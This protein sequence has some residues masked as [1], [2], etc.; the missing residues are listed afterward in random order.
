MCIFI[1]VLNSFVFVFFA[2]QFYIFSIWMFMLTHEA[3]LNWLLVFDQLDEKTLFNRT[4]CIVCNACSQFSFE[5]LFT[6]LFDENCKVAGAVMLFYSFIYSYNVQF[7]RTPSIYLSLLL[8]Q[9][10]LIYWQLFNCNDVH[11]F[12]SASGHR[13]MNTHHIC[14]FNATNIMHLQHRLREQTSIFNV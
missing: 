5:N 4:L 12:L 2:Q 10:G 7:Y 1:D 3:G 13:G 9:T 6:L 14:D 11:H 8:H